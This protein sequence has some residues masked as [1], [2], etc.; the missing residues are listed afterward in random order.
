MIDKEIQQVRMHGRA[1]RKYGAE[2]LLFFLHVHTSRLRSDGFAFNM[3]FKLSFV[4]IL[5]LWS[6]CESDR[7]LSLFAAHSIKY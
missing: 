3:K 7:M 1:F 2:V 4:L 5:R 6:G